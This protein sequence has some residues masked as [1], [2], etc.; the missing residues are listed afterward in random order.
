MMT[1]L[2]AVFAACAAPR[3]AALALL[4]PAAP[5]PAWTLANAL[6]RT[7]TFGTDGRPTTY[8]EPLY[9]AFLAALRL[10]TG[11]TTWLVLT[12]QVLVTALGGVLLYR[13]ADHVAGAGVAIVAAAIY[14]CYPYLVAQSIAYM[15]L[16]LTIVLMLAAT[17]ALATME[18]DRGAVL[19][20]VLFALLLL[21]R[22]T[23][24]FTL[25]AACVW[26]AWRGRGRAALVVAVTAAVAMSPWIARNL[27]VDGSLLPTRIGEN[28]LVSTSAFAESV[29]P[30]YDVDPLM[31]LVYAEAAASLPPDQAD[32]QRALDRA[33]LSRA[34]QF[35]REHP[36]RAARLKIRNALSLLDPRL[37]PRYP[38]GEYTIAVVRNGRIEFTGLR[39]RSRAQEL[40]Q[41]IAQTAV[42]ICAAA[43]FARRRLTI[44]DEPV[45]LVAATQALVCVVFFPSTRL[46]APAITLVFLYSA[47]GAV[48]LGRR[49]GAAR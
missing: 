20:G 18:S 4:P 41:A 43:A 25:A 17:L 2:A 28:L 9:P 45:L 30:A 39:A 5:T 29:I 14:A 26:L 22:A 49:I 46:L 24:G 36:L 40:V 34:L 38:A 15:D 44:R 35:V 12:A 47:A 48:D 3:L 21:Q 8:L 27:V 37:L 42:L 32:S 10:L 16:N 19:T 6:M 23:F 1:R 13:L 11:D 33:M 7:G 31:P